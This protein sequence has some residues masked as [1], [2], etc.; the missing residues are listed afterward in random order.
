MPSA[1]IGPSFA[2]D[3]V[4]DVVA[5]LIDSYVEQRDEDERFIDTVTRV[6]ID[7]FKDN[8]YRHVVPA[9]RDPATVAQAAPPAER[10]LLHE[11]T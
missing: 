5:R 4:P 3:E 11:A 10:R 6:G 2:A 1:M 8:V 7:P 9:Q